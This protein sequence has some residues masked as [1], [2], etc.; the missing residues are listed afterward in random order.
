MSQIVTAYCDEAR[1]LK[2]GPGL[3]Y[4]Q[5]PGE[6]IVFTNGYATFDTADFPDFAK[7]LVGAPPIE[8]LD[9]SAGEVAATDGAEF[10]CST[11]GKAFATKAKLNGHRMTHRP[12]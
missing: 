3:G 5:T 7:W 10:V 11:C 9:E 4:V 2:L 12:K 1:G 6:L 8:I